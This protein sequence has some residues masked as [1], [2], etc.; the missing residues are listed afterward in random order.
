MIAWFPSQE[1]RATRASGLS[2]VPPLLLPSGS[3][4]GIMSPLENPFK[5]GSERPIRKT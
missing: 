1:P 3:G 5:A 4:A 2:G